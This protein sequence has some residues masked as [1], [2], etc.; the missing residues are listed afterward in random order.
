MIL[1]SRLSKIEKK[2][3][4]DRRV[5]YQY[6]FLDY[7]AYERGKTQGVVDPNGGRIIILSDVLD[8]LEKE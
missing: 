2:I 6:I 3:E 1:E 7:E 8:K 4:G 5:N